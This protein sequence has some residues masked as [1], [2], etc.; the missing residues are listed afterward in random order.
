MIK[1]ILFDF[2]GVLAEEAFK[3]G[4]ATLGKEKGFDPNYFFNILSELAYQ[5]GYITGSADE[6]AYWKAVRE[7]TG[8]K[9]EDK[10]LREEV[11]IRLKL[12]PE[13]IEVVKKLKSSGF[14][15]AIL[16]DQTN[17]LDY[18]NQ[19]TPFYQHFDHVF[20][21]FYIKKTK[22]DPSLFRD[23]CAKLGL[24]PEEVLFVDDSLD[25]IKR[26]A[27]EG[28]R[29]IHFRGVNEFEKEIQK[30]IQIVSKRSND[31][32]EGTD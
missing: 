32:E 26:A 31:H 8:A 2:G 27:N 10:D 22:R 24:K 28:L 17:W 3:E 19:R 30:F 1:A 5:T 21:S 7:K 20:N 9:G 25:N 4:L 18:L 23:I 16:S 13:M 12:R 11:L 29:T 14:I 6:H 15:V